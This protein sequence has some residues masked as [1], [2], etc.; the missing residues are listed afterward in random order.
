MARKSASK[1]NSVIVL[2]SVLFLLFSFPSV[3]VGHAVG[4]QY[5]DIS[6]KWN[7]NQVFTFDQIQCSSNGDSSSDSILF[8]ISITQN[9]KDLSLTASPFTIG[10]RTFTS[11]DFYLSFSDP[12]TLTGSAQ[13]RQDAG[14][15]NMT[16][17]TL[18]I[19]E[20]C[21]TLM[22]NMIFLY[23]E[24]NDAS[25]TCT[26]GGQFIASRLIRSGCGIKCAENWECSD[27][28]NCNSGTQKRLCVDRNNCGASVSKP[29]ESQGC[30][31]PAVVPEKKDNT[32]MYLIIILAI[33]I[34]AAG[35]ILIRIKLKG[36]KSDM[37]GQLRSGI[38]SIHAAMNR[39]DRLEAM[40][41]Y[42]I[43]GERF[44][45]YKP[46]IKEEEYNRLYDDVLKAYNRILQ[47]NS[48]F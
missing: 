14:R 1:I 25:S 45:E 5:P 19:S 39:G 15:L 8:P 37:L 24:G 40:N 18:D 23:N 29:A 9:G 10:G 42:K 47:S 4:E 17:S 12:K 28:G 46:F 43:F 33:L 16:F 35:T 31:L 30:Q 22:G 36:R 32:W 38:E 11:L 21:N 34:A 20:D 13:Y 44:A 41:Q 6:G 26:G 7:V 48:G 2:L 3:F 27:W